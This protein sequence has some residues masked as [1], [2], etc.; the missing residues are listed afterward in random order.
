MAK[1]KTAAT[2]PDENTDE[3]ARAREADI[4]ARREA[5][6]NATTQEG[7]PT[8]GPVDVNEPADG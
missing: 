7:V 1:K 3:V 6:E 2:P 8:P 4:E 5:R